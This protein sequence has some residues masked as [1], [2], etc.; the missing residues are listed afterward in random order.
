MNVKRIEKTENCLQLTISKVVRLSSNIDPAVIR[1]GYNVL[2][3]RIIID[4]L[5]W[6]LLLSQLVL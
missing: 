6:W 1:S 5:Y 2:E 3:T 4:I